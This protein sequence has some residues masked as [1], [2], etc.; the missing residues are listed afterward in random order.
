MISIYKNVRGFSLIELLI[1]MSISLSLVALVA[2]LTIDSSQKYKVKAEKLA[3]QSLFRKIS[4][5][6]FISESNLAIEVTRNKITLKRNGDLQEGSKS[7]ILQEDFDSIQFE[8]VTFSVNQLGV[9]Q[10][11]AITYS[12]L[13][14]KATFL[15]VK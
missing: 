2:G 9:F 6:A 3:L 1:V 7:I 10:L 13:S 4:S 15:L 5:F 12:A 11:K 8:P 14:K